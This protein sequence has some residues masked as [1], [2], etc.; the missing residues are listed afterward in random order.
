MVF[1]SNHANEAYLQAP[2]NIPARAPFL[3]SF[4]FILKECVGVFSTLFTHTASQH[5]TNQDVLPTHPEISSCED[6]LCEAQWKD[7]PCWTRTGHR[8]L[9]QQQIIHIPLLPAPHP[10]PSQGRAHTSNRT[11][12]T[13]PHG[14]HRAE[15]TATHGVQIK[16]AESR[17]SFQETRAVNWPFPLY[18]FYY[19]FLHKHQLCVKCEAQT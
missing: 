11:T 4:I 9:F 8:G 19:Y 18:L 16:G 3:F 7:S 10:P 6:L 13:T 12:R 5:C 2:C 14:A 1:D 15:T 17:S